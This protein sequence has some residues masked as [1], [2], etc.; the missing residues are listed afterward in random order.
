M[1]WIC[2]SLCTE[3]LFSR[4]PGSLTVRSKHHLQFRRRLSVH[5]NGSFPRIN[6]DV[7]VVEDNSKDDV[8]EVTCTEHAYWLPLSLKV[9]FPCELKM[10]RVS[11]LFSIAAYGT[12][13]I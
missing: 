11:N 3:S 12:S 6:F 13:G 9:G 4:A 8:I 7:R 1:I 2:V 5:K 10:I